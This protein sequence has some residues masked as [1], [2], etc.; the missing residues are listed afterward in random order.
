MAKFNDVKD[1]VKLTMLAG[2]VPAIV[3][4]HG[5]GKSMMMKE[6][7]A[8]MGLDLITIESGLLKEGTL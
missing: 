1:C 8:D 7:A 2:R 5:L 6:V 3:G 4:V